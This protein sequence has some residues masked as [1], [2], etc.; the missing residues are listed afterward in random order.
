MSCL[1]FA[2]LEESFLGSR[3]LSRGCA[4]EKE[5]NTSSEFHVVLC[6]PTGHSLQERFVLLPVLRQN[7]EQ[8]SSPNVWLHTFGWL[9]CAQDL[10]CESI[11][12]C[13]CFGS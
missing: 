5:L 10:G 9:F 7:H 12:G 6:A 3:W 13:L 4:V 1:K 2:G 11:H 8:S